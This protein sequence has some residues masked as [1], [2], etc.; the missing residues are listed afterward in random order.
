M[1]HG[2]S[3]RQVCVH[4]VLKYIYIKILHQEKYGFCQL[5]KLY[6]LRKICIIYSGCACHGE[7]QE[8]IQGNEAPPQSLE[9]L[10][11]PLF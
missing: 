8:V 7:G 9:G 1:L 6:K 5:Y 10:I 4:S 11:L 3:K 2:Q